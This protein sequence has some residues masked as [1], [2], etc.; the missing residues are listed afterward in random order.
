MI[1]GTRHIAQAVFLPMFK[2][3]Q[4]AAKQWLTAENIAFAT[5]CAIATLT[6]DHNMTDPYITA[7]GCYAVFA[8]FAL[9]A[10]VCTKIIYGKPV[11]FDY[12]Q[13]SAIF[14]G[15]CLTEAVA[16]MWRQG[17]HAGISGIAGDFDN[18]AGFAACTSCGFA[19]AAHRA[20]TSAE[21]KTHVWLWSAASATLLL[22]TSLSACRSGIMSCGVVAAALCIIK[23]RRHRALVTLVLTTTAI[24]LVIALYNLKPDSANGRLLI[25]NATLDMIAQKPLFGWGANAFKAHYMNFQATW[26]MHHPG[27]K[28]AMLADNVPVAYNEY[29]NLLACYGLAGLITCAAVAVW[30]IRNRY[31][32]PSRSKTSALLVLLAI[33]VMSLSSYPLTYALTWVAIGL[34]LVPF[35]K[36]YRFKSGV[37]AIAASCFA[38]IGMAT[39]GA[40]IYAFHRWNELSLSAPTQKVL[41]GYDKL[42][43]WLGSNP[44]FLYNHAVMLLDADSTKKALLVAENCDKQWDDYDLELLLA[45]THTAMHNAA[46]AIAHYQKAGLMCPSRFVPPYELMNAYTSIGDTVTARRYAKII[47]TKKI[48]IPTPAT[49]QIIAEAHALLKTNTPDRQNSASYFEH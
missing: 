15:V 13:L 19:I 48:K 31:R 40:Y 20:L 38:A 17:I 7:K 41:R 5:L 30:L 43:P 45:D 35:A 27:S 42:T 49:H 22:A 33:A 36:P 29:L 23:T 11:K 1:S 37:L 14:V 3:A 46:A 47:V 16:A 21:S 26:L 6:V 34:S 25:W 24:A 28:A 4:I 10:V 18:P 2:A 9:V 8:C 44:Y 39:T 12:W 32:K